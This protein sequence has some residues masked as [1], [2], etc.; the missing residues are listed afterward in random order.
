M[1]L[2]K[3][4]DES[5]ETSASVSWFGGERPGLLFLLN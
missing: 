2:L 4:K 5:V 1:Y 3:G